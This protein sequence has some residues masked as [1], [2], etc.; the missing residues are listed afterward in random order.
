[1]SLAP[2]LFK[3]VIAQFDQATWDGVN[4]SGWA[5]VGNHILIKPDKASEITKGGVHMTPDI[6]ARATLAAEAGIV[7]A[8]GD[9]AFKWNADGVTLY[10]GMKPQAGDR[11]FTERYAGQLVTGHDGEI[12]RLMS[13]SSIGAIQVKE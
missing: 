3:T 7:I 8:M 12:Y 5:P 1:M 6:V 10:E 2:K 4:H 11:V 9:G 13:S